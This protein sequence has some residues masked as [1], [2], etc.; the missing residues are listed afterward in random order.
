MKTT[1]KQKIMYLILFMCFLTLALPGEKAIASIRKDA[2]ILA[3]KGQ[4]KK[5]VK[6]SSQKHLVQRIDE[7]L[8]KGAKEIRFQIDKKV[9]SNVDS[10][11][12]VF[13]GKK[14]RSFIAS[15]LLSNIKQYSYEDDY[16]Q[17]S[18]FV[19]I[20]LTYKLPNKELKKIISNIKKV[21]KQPVIDS[22]EEVK[23]VFLDKLYTLDKKFILKVSKPIYKELKNDFK[24]SLEDEPKYNDLAEKVWIT[25]SSRIYPKFGVFEFDL[26]TKLIKQQA[27]DILEKVTPIIHSKDELFK[28]I[29]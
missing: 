15:E 8:I 7:H 22:R 2:G 19:K 16:N 17:K 12:K 24:T 1:M 3:S 5:V 4:K 27:D 14:N 13:W 28:E 11:D 6:I 26:D 21:D 10:F 29:V 18:F 20:K 9:V 23:K 25:Q